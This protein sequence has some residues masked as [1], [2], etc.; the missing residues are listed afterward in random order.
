MAQEVSP[1]SYKDL[2]LFLATA[3]I[4]APIFKRLKINPILGYLLAG[5]I[6]GPFGLGRFIHY[7]PWLDYV[8]VDNPEEIAQ[9]AE[10]GVV[11]LLFMIGLELSW[12][13]LRLMRKLVFGLGAVQVI[14]CSLALGAG[15]MLMGQSPVAA[16]TIGAALTLSSTAIAIPVL[17]ERRRLHSEGGR[18]T[19]SVLLFQDLAVAPILITLAI[20]GRGQGSFQLKDLL[21]LAPAAIGLGAIVL[22]GR[23]A[24]RP[25]L[26]SVAKAK[27]EEMFMAACLLVIIGAGMVSALSGLSMA[28]GAF[29]AGVLLAE[30]EYRH[31]V[32]VK[33]EPFKGLLLSLFFVSLG[34]RLDLS[35][36]V[37]QPGLI[38]TTALGLLVVKAILV[39]GG[40]LIMGLSRKAALEAALILAAGGEF[41]FVLLDNA[42]SAKVVA[43]AI[44]QAVLVS[45]TLTMFLI[46]SLAALGAYLARKGAAPQTA[47]APVGA[48]DRVGPEPAGQVLV[49]G[50]GR[51]GKLV[52]GMLNRH[53]LPWIAV[54]R[55][56]RLVEQGRREGGRIYYG[57]ASR[58]EL[59]ERCGLATARAVVIT[60]DAPEGAE[61]VVAAARG[62]RP[63]VP[64][65]VRARDAR[66]AARLYELG[67]TDAVPETIEASLQLSE[68]V[69]V[70]IGVPMG[71]VI[72]SIH[73]RRDEYRKVLNRPD[74]LGGR[75]RR[76]RD[77][78]LR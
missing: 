52:S 12:E 77:A 11:F 54:E 1:E 35:L 6:L 23:L 43:P 26:K 49:V 48:P 17:A 4:V 33:I 28:L 38:L 60:M 76:L 73:E 41:A 62:A 75:R 27:S 15:A 9:L 24:L 61:A 31:E 50:Y 19:F 21:A 25:M 22:V 63:D 8:T 72:A 13:R 55:D 34:I 65:V 59:L 51:V 30:T 16:L 57:D 68:A 46:P 32:E 29:V 47:E 53:D 58:L 78:S 20:L 2:V 74:A 42:M 71:L 37:A 40:G 69:L 3:G 64:I 44:G 45:A 7:A 36:L 14:G 39:F 56:A 66:H 67:A 70:D 18:A 10:F 5:V